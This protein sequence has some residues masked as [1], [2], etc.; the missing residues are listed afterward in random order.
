MIQTNL[1]E[2]N[3]GEIQ[4][5]LAKYNIRG[6]GEDVK[7]YQKSLEGFKQTFDAKHQIGSESTPLAYQ[8]FH[9]EAIYMHRKKVYKIIET[10]LLPNDEDA[11]RHVIVESV[12][13]PK[14]YTTPT[15][16]K[17]PTIPSDSEF[18]EKI[19]GGVKIKLTDLDIDKTV[20]GYKRF[21]IY[22]DTPFDEMIDGQVKAGKDSDGSDVVINSGTS[23][24]NHV[25]GCNGEEFTFHTRGIVLDIPIQINDTSQV[26][27]K[28]YAVKQEILDGLHVIEHVLQH[29][30]VTIANISHENLDG[31]YEKTAIG[32]EFKRIYVYDDSGDGESG[33]VEAIF[34]NIEEVILR[35]FEMLFLCGGPKNSGCDEPTGLLQNVL[36]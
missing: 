9:K 7:V 14:Y 29:A 13:N 10:H 27:D 31:I 35:A 36:S 17:T 12:S 1:F 24:Q 11:D 33:A 8:K 34:H 26:G 5:R 18:S 15:V 20:R 4:K 23:S 16:D 21:N 2:P 32:T 3:R 19:I 6:M 28:I 22:N 30:G 25:F